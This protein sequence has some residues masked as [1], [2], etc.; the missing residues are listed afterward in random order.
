VGLVAHQTF[1]FPIKLAQRDQARAEL[2]KIQTEQRLAGQAVELEVRKLY[3]D[4]RQAVERARAQA[5]AEKRARQWATAAN[6]SFE[7]GTTDTRDLIE[8]LV[9]LSLASTEKLTAWHDA[10]VGVRALSGAIG[11]D[12]DTGV[13]RPR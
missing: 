11:A 7:L 4:L 6:A 9:A 10:Q 12:V 3:N 5:D 13:E 2:D 8:A 1:D